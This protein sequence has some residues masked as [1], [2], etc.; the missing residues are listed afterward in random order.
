M[1]IKI[2][3]INKR[4]YKE[5]LH[6]LHKVAVE[7]LNF[8][9]SSM[10]SYRKLFSKKIIGYKVLYKKNICGFIIGTSPEGGVGTIIWLILKKEFRGKK[11]GKLLFERI[12]QYYKSKNCH[13]IKLTVP[14]R[15]ALKFYKRMGMKV[16]GFHR[17]HWWKM[18][19]WSLGLTI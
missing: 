13:K 3:K 12:K 16:E 2:K 17:K 9:K 18:D 4:D 5:I 15:K 10:S 11:L 7:E 19:F 8:P 6:I 1:D 14:T